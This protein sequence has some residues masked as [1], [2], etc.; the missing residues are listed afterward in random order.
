VKQNIKIYG[1]I[2]LS[3]LL[4]ASG[5]YFFKF[6]NNFSFG[7]VS[8]IAVLMNKFY[9][10]SA[11]DIVLIL[12]IALL[13]VGFIFLGKSFGIKTVYSS[14]L[15]SFFISLLERIAPLTEPL[16]NEPMLELAFAIGLPAVG[17]AIL[18][19]IGASSGGTD[20]IAL[21]LQ[22]YSSIDIGR[23]LFL[24]DLLITLSVFLVFDIKA[25]LFSFLGLMI[26]SLAIDGVIESINMCKF[27]NIVCVDPEPICNYI[28]NNLHRGAT[29]CEAVGAF[30]HTNKYI[31]L[32]ALK[33]S[34]AVRLRQYIK[35]VE[36]SAF[37]MI[38]NTSEIIGKGFRK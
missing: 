22:K 16:T 18:F 23:A 10:L 26:K 9:M 35:Q 12:N 1:L 21:I 28:V 29:Y 4:I 38:S 17:A 25:G 32:T 36:P 30:S 34:Q 15:M 5:V 27:F 8:G 19:N 7:G 6:Q 13:L 31:I 33:R 2:T 14:L 11:G 24:T 3:Q 20:I 37:I